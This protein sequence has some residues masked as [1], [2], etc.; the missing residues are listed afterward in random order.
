MTD[1]PVPLATRRKS[2]PVYV[3]D[4][5]VG[6]DAPVV[7]QTMTNTDTADVVATVG[8][9]QAL[10]VAGS[11]LVRVTVNTRVAARAVPE[12][13][14]RLRELSPYYKRA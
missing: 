3:G 4:V 2:R 13:V 5:Q 11:E 10:A 9:A 6:G 8:Q 12:I 14:A 1:E 7:V